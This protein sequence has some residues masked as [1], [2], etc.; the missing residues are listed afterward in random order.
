MRRA[1]RNG[2][3]WLTVV[4]GIP[5][6]VWSVTGFLFSFTDFDSVHGD[7]DRALPE[8]AS[9]ARG[10]V[11]VAIARARSTSPGA[12][13]VQVRT[14]VLLGRVVHVV[15]LA[16]PH[17]P[18]VVDDEGALRADVSAD[19]AQ[20]IAIAAYRGNVLANGADVVAS[21]ADAPNVPRPAYRV[22]LADPHHT[23]VFVSRS[24]GEI[25][26]WRNDSWRA[27]DRLWSLHVLGFVSRSSPA[28][29]PMRVVATLAALAAATGVALLFASL[30]RRIARARS[31][32]GGE[33]HG[34][35]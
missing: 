21:H 8:D 13:V 12:R 15:E 18:V 9:E 11:A 30:A 14:R 1:L 2:H 28:H 7:A 23:D 3:L 16:P 31:P 19:E 32:G 34:M 35:S 17:G 5:I 20:R 33:E 22:R 10:D 27:F 24:T 29:W 26:A 6:L 25:V 4:I